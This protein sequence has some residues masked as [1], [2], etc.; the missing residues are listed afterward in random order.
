MF[1]LYKNINTDS[2]S[3]YILQYSDNAF[4]LSLMTLVE[5][6]NAYFE[7]CVLLF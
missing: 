2:K 3:V 7:D 1:M 5:I 6:R 4:F